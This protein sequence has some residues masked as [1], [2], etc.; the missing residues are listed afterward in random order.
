MTIIASL[1]FMIA[2]GTAV[3]VIVLT[4]R[5]SMPRILEV[6]DMEFAPSVQRERRIIL[7]EMR[8]LAPAAILPFPAPARIQSTTSL[9]A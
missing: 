9:A 1:L 3:S 8:R 6:I 5:A 2:L 4:I 7:G